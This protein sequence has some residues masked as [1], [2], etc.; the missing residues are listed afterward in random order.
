MRY[1][2]PADLDSE[3]LDRAVAVL[4]EISRSAART[5]VERGGVLRAGEPALSPRAKVVAGEVLEFDIPEV[6]DRLIP[7]QVDYGTVHQDDHMLVVDKPSGLT[8]HPG[9][10]TGDETLAAGLLYDHPSIEGVGQTGRWG[11]VHRLDRATSGLLVVAL[12]AEAYDVLTAMMR[13]REVKRVY[14]ALVQ[15]VM[16]IPRGTVDAPI[17]PDPNRPTRRA[18]SPYGKHAVTHYRR[19]TAWPSHDVS[20]LDVTLE[21]GRTHQIRVHLAGIGNPVL[22]DR[23][24]GGKDPISA[25]R[26]ALHA[27]QL[28]LH[29]PVTGELLSFTSALPA[30]LTSVV[31]ELSVEPVTDHHG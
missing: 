30:D 18:L 14:Q 2:V 1:E 4:G 15:G 17:G 26:L 13:A 6:D 5:I 19:V 20:M 29:H 9:A 8:V 23:V 12:T 11:I 7:F 25:P 28:E 27:A 31:D 24:Y 22:G 16:A 10:A 21:T 3:R